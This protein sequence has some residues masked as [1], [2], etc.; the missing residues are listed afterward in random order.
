MPLTLEQYV[1]QLDDR[2]DLPWPAAPKIDPLKA[3]PS[4]HPMSIKAV[5]WT[6]YGTLVAVPQGEIIY[7][8]PQEF[9]TAAALEKVIKEFK[10]WNSMSRKPGAP[11]EYM[12]ELYNKAFTVMRLAGSGGEKFPELQ[13]E[14]VWDDI[15]K[16]L[17][18]K[19]YT[20]D[21]GTYGPLPE[22]VKKVTYFYHASI[23]GSGPYPGAADTLKL[24]ADQGVL[25]GLL[26]DGQCFTAGQLQ[27]CIKQQDPGFDLNAIIPPSMR[28]ISVEKK[29]RKPSETLFKAAA[30][31]VSAKGFSPSEV[32]HI[33]SNLT[34]DIAPAKKHGFRTALFA[35]D[36]ASLAATPEQLK[37]PALRPDA[38][39]TE[40]PQVLELIQ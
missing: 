16:K 18:L 12:K 38:L 23:Q 9:V 28:I 24:L 2:K 3:K 39:I 7:E 21:A 1:E 27:R 14:R 19:E 10:M 20:F 15:I 4:I 29:A 17:M 5:F 8:H 22:Y 30:S 25:Q 33:G 31:V 40:L 26:A 13:A 32:L 6:V 34:R 35:G 11:S 37:D 36:R